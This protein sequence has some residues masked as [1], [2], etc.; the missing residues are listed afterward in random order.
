MNRISFLLCF[1]IS[2]SAIVWAQTPSLSQVDSILNVIQLDESADSLSDEDIKLLKTSISDAIKYKNQSNFSGSARFGFNGESTRDEDNSLFAIYGGVNLGWDLYPGELDLSTLFG[3]NFTDGEIQENVSN[4]DISY[5]HMHQYLGDGLLLENYMYVK[6]T[7]DA[8]LGIDQRYEI[9]GGFIVNHWI[10][11]YVDPRQG[12]FPIGYGRKENKALW[13]N[14]VQPRLSE[15]QF[16][17]FER[18]FTEGF[19]KYKKSQSKLRVAILAGAYFELEQTSVNDSISLDATNKFRWV[20]RP[21]VDIRLND[22]W[23]LSFRP[24]FKMGMPWSWQETIS[25][26]DGQ[27]SSRTDYTVDF[28][29]K[30][31]TQLLSKRIRIDLI[32]NLVYD[33]SPPRTFYEGDGGY[34]LIVNNDLHQSY[35]ISV[36]V[37]LAQK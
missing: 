19:N 28:T 8:Y 6:R 29:G 16:E 10:N 32:Y 33:N 35:R 17:D 24:Y 7:T 22:G 12:Q 30:V 20:V 1:F 31:S 21:T 3:I 36:S 25:A 11:R 5:D 27:T 9:G 2:C 13:N 15:N 34:E 14:L 18:D 26:P 4:I 23:R 37:N